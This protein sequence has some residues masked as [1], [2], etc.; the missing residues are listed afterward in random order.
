[1][2]RKLTIEIMALVMMI[3]SLALVLIT[4]SG[5]TRTY[6]IWIAGI[7]IACQ[8]LQIILTATDS[9]DDVE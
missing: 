2:G 8:I 5:Q 7:T 3:G 1:M 4:L 6:G 9:S